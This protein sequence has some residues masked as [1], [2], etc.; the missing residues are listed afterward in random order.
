MGMGRKNLD[1]VSLDNSF[2]EFC[3]KEKKRDGPV[4]ILGVC[5]LY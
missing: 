3:C 2:G 1:T 5:V 4:R